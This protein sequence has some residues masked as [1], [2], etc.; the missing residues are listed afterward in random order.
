MVF[1]NLFEIDKNKK[2]LKC[3]FNNSTIP[4]SSLKSIHMFLVEVLFNHTEKQKNSRFF[5]R[6]L[7]VI[8]DVKKGDELS[9]ENIR[10]LRPDIGISPKY[11]ASVIGRKHKKDYSIGTLLNYDMITN[12]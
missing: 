8:K 4:I 7:I 9:F 1:D 5:S 11:Y 2:L 6:S 12:E 3:K 10:F